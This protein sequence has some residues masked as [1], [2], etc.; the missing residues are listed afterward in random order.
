MRAAMMDHA[1]SAVPFLERAAGLFGSREVITATDA[2][3]LRHSWSQIRRRTGRLRGALSALDVK[4]GDRVAT[5]AWNDHRHL[6]LYFG[7]PGVGA[8]MAQAMGQRAR[9]AQAGKRRDR[10]RHRAAVGH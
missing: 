5:L 9:R 7:V 10:T 3:T 1:L 2:G 6:E 4:G 8:V